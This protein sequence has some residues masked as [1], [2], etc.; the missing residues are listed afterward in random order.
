MRKG[1]TIWISPAM[2]IMKLSIWWAFFKCIKIK[3]E[4]DLLKLLF[5]YKYSLKKNDVLLI[6]A[7]SQSFRV[8]KEQRVFKMHESEMWRW[9]ENHFDVN[10]IYASLCV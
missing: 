5:L 6:V 4:P 9:C 2:R 8:S 1:I 10:R 7:H 3:N